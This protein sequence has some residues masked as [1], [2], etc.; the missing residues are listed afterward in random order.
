[1]PD[2]PHIHINAYPDEN[3]SQREPQPIQNHQPLNASASHFSQPSLL[4]QYG[5]PTLPSQYPV[6]VPSFSPMDALLQSM[7]AALKPVLASHSQSCLSRI[8]QS[9]GSIVERLA[10]IVKEMGETQSNTLAEVVDRQYKRHKKATKV[11]LQRLDK[12][13][14]VIE[15]IAEE[16]RS[17]LDVISSVES[18]VGGILDKLSDADGALALTCFIIIIIIDLGITQPLDT[19]PEWES[20][21]GPG[22]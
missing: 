9:E 2:I 3:A 13:E 10:C 1:M 17:L 19:R 21:E 8:E 11:V 12:L 16:N 18:A 20:S 6:H 15:S 22:W 14:D 4:R 5:N 7:V